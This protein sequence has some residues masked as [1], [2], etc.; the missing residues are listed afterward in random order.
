MLSCRAN[1]RRA[2]KRTQ[3]HTRRDVTL[4]RRPIVLHDNGYAAV[5]RRP[6]LARFGAKDS[7]ASREGAD[8]AT[9]PHT[10]P[11]PA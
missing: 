2:A 10:P 8:Y 4:A 3:L 7:S 6:R 11:T 1:V 9:A 5:R